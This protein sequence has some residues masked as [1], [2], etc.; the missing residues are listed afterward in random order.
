MK[1]CDGFFVMWCKFL[2]LLEYFTD[3]QVCAEN[4]FT[5]MQMK[6][7]ILLFFIQELWPKLKKFSPLSKI[8]TYFLAQFRFWKKKFS[9]EI[10]TSEYSY[11]VSA[12]P[13]FFYLKQHFGDW[14]LSPSSDKS[15]LSWA[16][17][18]HNNCITIL[19]PQTFRSFLSS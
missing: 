11:C 3:N 14:I 15:L 4:Y 10:K 7:V 13:G 5:C 8:F 17:R 18:I 12:F 2:D 16:W 6:Q 9:D 1:N 19:S